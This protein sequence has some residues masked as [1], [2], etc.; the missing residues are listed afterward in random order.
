[1]ATKPRSI[2]DIVVSV[3]VR[4]GGC[5]AAS[6]SVGQDASGS[7]TVGDKAFHF[8]A[9]VIYG[10]DQSV[11]FE[12]VA[13]RL[14]ARLQEGFSVTLLAY[15]QTG[16]F[17]ASFHVTQTHHLSVLTDN[18]A[19]H[20]HTVGKHTPCLVRQAPSPKPPSEEPVVA[21]PHRGVS[22]RDA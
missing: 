5:A 10:S 1:M 19:C 15:G 6:A 2:H 16:R 13:S 4:P 12:A 8:P 11:A 14:L 3:R 17:V 21:F 7:L 22:F 18:P 20:H 9:A